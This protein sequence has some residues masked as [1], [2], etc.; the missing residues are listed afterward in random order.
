MLQGL[1]MSARY[2]AALPKFLRCPLSPLECRQRIE[3]QLRNREQTF[4]QILERGIFG[5]PNSPYR[6]LLANAGAEFGD[7]AQAVRANGIE[8]TLERLHG[9]GVYVT[10]DEFKGR[11]PIKRPGLELP[12]RATDFDNPLLLK[13]YETRTGGSRGVRRRLVIDLDLLTQEAAYFHFFLAGFGLEGRRLAAWREVPP[14]GAGLKMMLRYA[15][16]GKPPAKWFTQSKPLARAADLGYFLFTRYT[17]YSSRL[18]GTPLP[19]PEHVPA[20]EAARIAGW[21]AQVKTADGTPA[22][23]ETNASSGVRICLAAV[24]HGLDIAGTFFRLGGEPYTA[25]KAKAIAQAGARG[26]CHYHMSEAGAIGMACAAPRT[27]GEVH[28][29]RD[30]MAVIQRRVRVGGSE[31]S[32]GA[33]ICTTLLPSCPKIML[34]VESGDYG[35]LEN[36]RCGCVFDELGFTTHLSEIYSYE[37]LT[38]AG[39][40]FLGKELIALVEEIL[41]ARF[42]G[43]PTDYQF[44]EEERNGLPKVR[45]LVSPKV[46][47]VDEAEVLAAALRTLRSCPGGELM[48]DVWQTGRMLEVS[49]REPYTTGAF[50]VLP[51]HILQKVGAE[52]E[53]Q[54]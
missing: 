37:K 6:K 33:L 47:E 4:L 29:A 40:T 14:G 45:L 25:A 49:R 27:R 13:H 1:R 52:S 44:V 18:S 12:V 23:L 28:I 11:Q 34:N 53:V 22:L 31:T 5:N 7:I 17:V 41:P 42:G 35:V 26:A 10:L 51:L 15:K 20:T 2:A 39:V 54:V 24:E 32:V 3:N 48:A 21:L 50:K 9:E 36:R 46:G 30:K 16:L 19:A 8:N 38:S 43:C